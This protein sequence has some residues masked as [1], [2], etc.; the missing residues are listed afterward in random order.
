MNT[1]QITR[2]EPLEPATAE[3]PDPLAKITLTPRGFAA[4]LATIGLLL[5]LILA[6]VPVHVAGP[7][8]ANPG[9]VSCGNTIGGVE[10][11]VAAGGLDRPDRATVVSYVDICERAISSRTFYSWPMFLAGGLVI[12]WLGAVRH[13][14]NG[15][16]A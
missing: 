3:E 13:R 5:G 16:P 7:D 14:P 4:L 2:V 8:P 15:R 10:T 6:I 9:Y 11:D 1:D 12:I